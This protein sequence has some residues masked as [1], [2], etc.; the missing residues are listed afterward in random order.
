MKHSIIKAKSGWRL[1]DVREWVDFFDLFIILIN[2]DIKLRYKQTLLG[3]FWVILQPLMTSVMF[4]I[5]F[6]RMGKMPSD[7][8][9]YL[10]FALTGVLPW[11]IFSQSVLKASTSIINQAHL[12]S[13]VYFPR[14]MI[15]ASVSGASLVDFVINLSVVLGFCLIYG[16]YPSWNIFLLIPLTILLLFLS[17]GIGLL[18]CALN[19]FY[20]DFSIALPF[21]IQIW[22]FAS[23]LVYSASMVPEKWRVIYSINPIA[24]L[25]DGYRWAFFGLGDFPWFSL[26]FAAF[27]SISAFLLGALLFHR[28]ERQFADVI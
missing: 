6:G 4:T 13:K 16:V 11:S 20:R 19:V 25:I 3:V 15:P 27:F 7:G 24:G 14:M 26:G 1:I 17:L 9:P 21:L 2:R 8:I 18:F 5:V 12:I 23:P 28:V 10:L 22:M